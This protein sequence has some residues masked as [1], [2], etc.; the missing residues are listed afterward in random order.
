MPNKMFLIA[1]TALIAYL[2]GRQAGRAKYA[3]HEDLRHQAERL[4]TGAGTAGNGS[5]LARLLARKNR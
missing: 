3:G 4:L 1:V 2:M 5:G